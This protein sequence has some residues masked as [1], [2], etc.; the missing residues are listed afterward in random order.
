MPPFTIDP[1]RIKLTDVTAT[2]DDHDQEN[3]WLS[4]SHAWT[5]GRYDTELGLVVFEAFDALSL[6]HFEDKDVSDVRGQQ[7]AKVQKVQRAR[8]SNSCWLRVK[9]RN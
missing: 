5:I 7:K 1:N 8:D 2:E 9:K 6:L 4:G 3:R